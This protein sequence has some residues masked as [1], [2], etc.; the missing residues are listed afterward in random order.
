MQSS[1]GMAG[2]AL[3]MLACVVGMPVLALSGTSWSETLK[4]L[5]DFRW[6]AILDFASASSSAPLGEAPRFVPSTAPVT[7]I[8]RP[9]VVIQEPTQQSAVMPAGY[10]A[11]AELSGATAANVAGEK[12]A[13]TAASADLFHSIQDRLRQLGATYY[14]LE[15]WGTQ[16]QMYRFYCKMAVAGSTDY[17]RCFEAADADPLQAMVQVLRQVETWKEGGGQRVEG[18]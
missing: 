10:Q 12:A 5:Q 18:G 3:I 14:L 4:K 16:R 1:A 2:R 11:P 13:D 15:S 17:T 8:E 6:P 7:P 9:N